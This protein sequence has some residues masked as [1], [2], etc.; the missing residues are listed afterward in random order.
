MMDFEF[1]CINLKQLKGI[2]Y[3]YIY[4]KSYYTLHYKILSYVPTNCSKDYIKIKM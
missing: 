4:N 3:L 1:S 2:Y